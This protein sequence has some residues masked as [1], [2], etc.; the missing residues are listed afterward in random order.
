ME[1]KTFKQQIKD[2]WNNNKKVIKV[3]FMFGVLGVAYGFVKGMATTDKMWLDHGFE[4]ALD[5]NYISCDELAKMTE[6][7]CDD[8]KLL[9]LVKSEDENS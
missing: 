5:E 2:W 1:K 4:R 8:P 6:K 9:E 3:G 7:D